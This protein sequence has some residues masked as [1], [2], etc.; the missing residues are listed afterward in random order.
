MGSG[1]SAT[2]ESR[3]TANSATREQD[4]P[5]DAANDTFELGEGEFCSRSNENPC[6]WNF[7]TS[8]RYFQRPW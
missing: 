2:T 3:N 1:C 6:D 4:D 7:Q 8:T 5:F